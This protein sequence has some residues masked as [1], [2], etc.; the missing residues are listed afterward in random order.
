MYGATNRA[1]I[2]FAKYLA[3]K[4]F[5][6]ILIDREMKGLKELEKAL[7]E[8]FKT[9]NPSIHLIELNQFDVDTLRACII[10]IKDL[11]VKLFINC[12]NSKQN[13]QVPLR[14]RKRPFIN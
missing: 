2:A 9:N 10:P 1:G 4:G 5:N 3:G 7:K 14:I 11:P 12:K 8:L 13:S 6:L